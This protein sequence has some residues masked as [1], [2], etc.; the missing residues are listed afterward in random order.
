MDI[1]II[2]NDNQYIKINKEKCKKLILIQTMIEMDREET[3][4]NINIDSNSFY[5]IIEFMDLNAYVEHNEYNTPLSFD[6]EK[7]YGKDG[8]I[9]IKF[10]DKYYNSLDNSEFQQLLLAAHFL[11]YNDLFKVCA[12]KMAFEIQNIDLLYKDEEKIIKYKQFFGIVDQNNNIKEEYKNEEFQVEDYNKYKKE[13][14]EFLD[15]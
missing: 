8:I 15:I 1:T 6:L 3:E 12:M 9:I 11:E 7:D 13:N 14:N 2:T 4:F 5:Q 10:V